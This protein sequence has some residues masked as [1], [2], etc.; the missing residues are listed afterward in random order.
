MFSGRHYNLN[1]FRSNGQQALSVDAEFRWDQVRRQ[2]GKVRRG[3]FATGHFPA[4]P[5]FVAVLEDLGMRTIVIFRDPRDMVVSS[6]FYLRSLK[7]HPL[8][9]RFSA[10]AS[11]DEAVSACIT[12]LGP[13]PQGRAHPS[14]T[15]R[16]AAY[17]P[18]LDCP[19]VLTVRFEDLVGEAGGGTRSA[20]RAAVSAIAEHIDRPLDSAKLDR[21]CDRVF[22]SG[23]AT[24]RKGQIGDWR[25]HLTAEQV[26]LFKGEANE[27]LIRL[28]Y[29]DSRDW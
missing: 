13:D 28:G 7:R 10:F 9:A 15:D 2:Y 22:S 24:F 1:Q 23:S 25:N 29:E 14:I 5:E 27:Y 16:L 26:D 4:R 3:Q 17:T 12:G 21:V 19:S 18:W 11:V 8:H 20:Q 6:A